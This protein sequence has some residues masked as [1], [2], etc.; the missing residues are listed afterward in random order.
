MTYNK[1][2]LIAPCT[3]G[4]TERQTY[5]QTDRQADIDRRLDRQAC[6]HIPVEAKTLS[7]MNIPLSLSFC[8]NAQIAVATENYVPEESGHIRVTKG[9]V[10]RVV[11]SLNVCVSPTYLPLA[12]FL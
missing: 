5:I 10:V 6:A 1:S 2:V 4:D 11:L 7:H 8:T 3:P 12:H 9:D